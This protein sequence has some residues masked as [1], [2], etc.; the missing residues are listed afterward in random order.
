M[1]AVR[2]TN[3]T[4]TAFAAGLAAGALIL[5]LGVAIG[6]DHTPNTCN[7]HQIPSTA[8]EVTH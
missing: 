1:I 6:R 7:T 5:T 8:Q 4:V 2:A 3:S